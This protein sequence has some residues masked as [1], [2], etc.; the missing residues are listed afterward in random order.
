MRKRGGH[1]TKVG[2]AHDSPNQRTDQP[3]PKEEPMAQIRHNVL[4]ILTL[5][6]GTTAFDGQG[7]WQAARAQAIVSIKA[8]VIAT[9]I[10][11]ASA[12]S[13]VGAFLN[14]PVPP[15]CAHP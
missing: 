5:A 4:C 7:A 13:Q 8:H 14:N 11:G 15:A 1:E 12:I 6:A 9:N 3:K 10:P 2:A